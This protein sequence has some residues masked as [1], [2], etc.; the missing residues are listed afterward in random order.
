M[1]RFPMR[2]PQMQNDPK[3]HGLWEVTAP[4]A[5]S[6]PPLA[7]EAEAEVAIVGAGYAGLSAA[8]T[9]A[10]AGVSVC[11]LEAVEPGF[12]GAGRNV[13]LVNAGLWVMPE[14]VIAGLGPLYGNRLLDLLG[15]APAEVWARVAKHAIPCEANPVGTLHCANDAKG[16]AELAERERQWLSR[17]APVRLLS[18]AETE[19]KVGSRAY[20]GALLDQRAGTIQ[21]LAYARGLARAA[22]AAGARIHGQSPVSAIARRG[23]AWRLTTPQGAVSANWVIMA[24]DA[25]AHGPFAELRGRQV[26]LPYFNIATRPLTAAERGAILPEGQGAWDTREILSSFRLDAAGRMVFGSVG[27]LKGI[28]AAV[29]EAWARRAL[30]RIFPGLSGVDVQTRWFGKIGMTENSLPGFHQLDH[31]I[32]A[33][34]GY[35]GRG[36]GPGTVFGRCLA[37]HVT[38]ARPV[39]EMPLPPVPAQNRPLRALRERYYDFGA[40]LAH[41]VGDRL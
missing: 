33:I 11:L 15:A 6:C 3:S 17:G 41:L 12:G 20:K 22:L 13:G 23:E 32:V 5:P 27:A 19:T 39:E 8:L 38:G 18:A 37:E 29:H 28:G 35:N 36:I 24:G 34:S 16:R 14:A 9:L 10:E 31:N 25:Y 7:G 26:H 40:S 2:L 30:G 1:P 21:P 4:P